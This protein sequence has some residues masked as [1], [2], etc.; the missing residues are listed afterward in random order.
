MS[1]Q[2]MNGTQLSMTN[3]MLSEVLSYFCWRHS[4]SRRVKGGRRDLPCL[5]CPDLL[6]VFLQLQQYMQV[7]FQEATAAQG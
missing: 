4:P 6:A 2:R 1:L 3:L 7:S 5:S